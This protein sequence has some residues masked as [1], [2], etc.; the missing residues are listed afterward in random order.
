AWNCSVTREDDLRRALPRWR[1]RPS[2]IVPDGAVSL[3]HP[4]LPKPQTVL[5]EVVRA[6][7]RAGNRSVQRK[8]F[9]Y[10]DALKSGFFREVHGFEWVRTVVFLTPTMARAK[11]LAA[12]AADI[13]GGE[14]LLR[15]GAY[16]Q[17]TSPR[18]AP[19]SLLTPARLAQ[20]VLMTPAGRLVPF[21]PPPSNPSTPFHV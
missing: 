8:L 18:L 20:P 21:L 1:G 17:R 19:T 10:R 3:S 5:V 6:G 12:L 13:P 4:T 9:R 14:R 11:N 16:E 15:F 2:A 7:A